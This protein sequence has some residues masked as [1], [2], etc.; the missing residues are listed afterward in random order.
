MDADLVEGRR[1]NFAMC[2]AYD[3][4]EESDSLFDRLLG[5]LRRYLVDQRY[6]LDMRTRLESSRCLG[7]SLSDHSS[8]P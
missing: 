1:D 5:G 7:E 2:S 3:R 4:E 8:N 6:N